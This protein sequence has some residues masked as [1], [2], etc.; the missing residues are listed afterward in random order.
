MEPDNKVYVDTETRG[1]NGHRE[2][3]FDAARAQAVA[4]QLNQKT[5]KQPEKLESEVKVE[6]HETIVN[7]GK[8]TKRNEP[9]PCGSGKKYKVCCL[10][11]VGERP[12]YTKKYK[13]M[14][15]LDKEMAK[16]LN[17]H[18]K[19]GKQVKVVKE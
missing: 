12:T 9:C 17:K 7:A 2:Y 11:Q 1:L 8:G 16:R 14:I 15:V 18:I 4:D 6:I 13:R 5:I 19:A 3:H 10:R